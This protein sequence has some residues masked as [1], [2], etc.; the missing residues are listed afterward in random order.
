MRQSLPPACGQISS[1]THMPLWRAIDN[2]DIS[3]L[4]RAIKR[5]SDPRKPELSGIT[6]FYFAC[7]C[8][9]VG[10]VQWLFKHGA[11]ADISTTDCGGT[12]PL[13]IA[14]QFG[15]LKVVQWLYKNGA[16]QDIYVRTG[17]T[18]TAAGGSPMD[19]ALAFGHTSVISQLNEWGVDFPPGVS[20]CDS[21]AVYVQLLDFLLDRQAAEFIERLQA[22]V[23]HGFDVNHAE[24]DPTEQGTALTL[25]YWA[26]CERTANP[27]CAHALLQYSS[28]Q[29]NNG[30][31][32]RG[33][34]VPPLCVAA[35]YGNLE[36]VKLLTEAPGI[37]VNAR[38]QV[39]ATPAFA[40]ACK[41]GH[42]HVV[43]FMLG[44]PGL[45]V[46][47]ACC[48]GGTALMAAAENN[49]L[50][51][52]QILLRDGRADRSTTNVQG[53]NLMDSAYYVGSVKMIKL[54]NKFGLAEATSPDLVSRFGQ[55]QED[56]GEMTEQR[57]H[58]LERLEKKVCATCHKRSERNKEC[59]RCQSVSY[60]NE[61]CQRAGWG[62]HKAV[63]KQ[64]A[65]ARAS[66]R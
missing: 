2:G 35:E 28:V 34:K 8:G 9:E 47:A 25:L 39:D 21:R 46:N 43:E 59:A 38:L 57:T 40:K 45:D 3:L 55:L 62:E 61:E 13:M 36:Q 16:A 32:V 60:C 50:D 7:Q 27:A 5:G 18:A 33:D 26:C 66:A 30:G 42:T 17:A 15:H 12:T 19:M 51:V 23:R 11:A 6:P 31:T 58:T 10:V 22:A 54:L 64:L 52:V 56:G 37:I 44:V 24:P 65:R 49:H 29:V 4:Q 20:W 53:Y 41:N 63:C 1:L 14:C 48:K